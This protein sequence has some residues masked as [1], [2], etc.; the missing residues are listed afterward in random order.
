MAITSSCFR[1]AGSTLRASCARCGNASIN[2]DAV[3]EWPH[4]KGG[5]MRFVTIIAALAASAI[6]HAADKPCTN[7]QSAAAQKALDKVNS[8][9]QL[10]RAWVDSGHCDA[11]AVG[12]AYTDALLRLAIDGK[13]VPAFAGSVQK[14]AKYKEFVFAPL[15]SP[16]AKD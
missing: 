10:H 2:P 14:A 8:W 5:S 7:A 3:R 16:A 12:D 11:N 1:T 13:N 6:A 4:E 15:Q 9:D